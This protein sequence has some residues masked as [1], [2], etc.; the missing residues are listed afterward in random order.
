VVAFADDFNSGIVLERAA[1]PRGLLSTQVADAPWIAFHFGERRWIRGE[2]DGIC[3]ALR[4]GVCS[5]D[6]GG[7]RASVGLGTRCRP[8]YFGMPRLRL[9]PVA[10]AVT[11]YEYTGSSMTDHAPSTNTTSGRSEPWL[12]A[13][14]LHLFNAGVEPLTGT[15]VIRYKPVDRSQL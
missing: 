14:D 7:G 1:A 12:T 5:G 11:T 10:S 3:D 15:S 4:L 2:A 8:P 6:G 13:D 9:P